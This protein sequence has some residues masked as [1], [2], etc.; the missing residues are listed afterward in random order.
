MHSA[1]RITTILIFLIAAGVMIVVFL[2]RSIPLGNTAQ[3]RFD[4]IIVLGCPANGDGG[5]SPVQME[6][7]SEGVRQYRAGIA[8]MLI[9][10]GGAAHN[11]YV[12]AKVM[13]AIARAQG[14]PATAILEES[15]AQN[16]IQNAYYSVQIM[17]ARGWSSAEVVSSESHLPRASLIFARFPVRYRMQGARKSTDLEFNHPWTAYAYEACRADFIRIFGVGHSRYLP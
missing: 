7:V 3:A 11:R 14:V 4:T 17:K 2:Y 16:T 15:Q 8:P 12:E 10:T 9:M 5:P 6:R 13:A 1:G